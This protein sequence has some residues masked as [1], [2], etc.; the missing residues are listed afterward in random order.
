MYHASA[1]ASIHV[2]TFLGIVAVLALGL[3]SNACGSSPTGAS[4]A[5]S[6]EV[7]AESFSFYFAEAEKRANLWFCGERVPGK[8]CEAMPA[9]PAASDVM[10]RVRF[11]EEAPDGQTCYYNHDTQIITVPA[12]KW[13]SGCVPHEILHATLDMIRNSCWR[14]VEH[15]PFD[16]GC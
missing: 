16:G 5:A 3:V 8:S 9:L 7:D 10:G 4:M 14:D 6:T 13:S 1:K 12:D 15:H 11:V 2:R